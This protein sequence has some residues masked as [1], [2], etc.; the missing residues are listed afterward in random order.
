MRRLKKTFQ[1]L[2][3]QGRKGFVAYITAGD[4]DLSATKEN[5]LLLAEQG[6][7]VVELGV[8]FSDPLADG[9]INQEAANRALESGTTFQGILE[10]VSDV[11]KE[12]DIPIVF[13]SY[14]NPLYAQ[15]FERAAKESAEAGV[16]GMLILDLS[17]EESSRYQKILD[18]EGLDHICLVTPTTPED[19]IK[20]IVRHASGF[21]YCVSRTGV[22]GVQSEVQ[23]GAQELV[24][25]T[26]S[27]T[28][29][30]VVLGFGIST[31]EQAASVAAYADAIVV[32]S[33]I[34]KKFHESP[35]TTEG[36]RQAA[37]WVGTL[38]QAAHSA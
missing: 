24:E 2:K 28:K 15:G 20:K 32:G 25:S 13:F 29:L 12:C 31:P 19:R 30:P 8:P 21:V 17:L 34:V 11:R 18:G 23:S 5:I 3:R 26:K 38:V 27:F 16:D 10:M 37:E 35:H 6:V 1:E 36:R 4:P 9:R 22:T 33:A 14:F 7:D